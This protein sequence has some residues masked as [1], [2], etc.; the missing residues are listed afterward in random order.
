MKWILLALALA[1]MAV[2]LYAQKTLC[3]SKNCAASP[4][5]SFKL[6]RNDK[7]LAEIFEH[8]ESQLPYSPV[9]PLTLSPSTRQFF[10]P[11]LTASNALSRDAIQVPSVPSAS[12][13][14]G[15]ANSHLRGG[16][17]FSAGSPRF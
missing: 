5:T 1:G 16:S 6:D 11:G 8:E 15:S 3:F 14:K 12:M 7:D 13:L 9:A 17:I 2:P 4:T 10:Q